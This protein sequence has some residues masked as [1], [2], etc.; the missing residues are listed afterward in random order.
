MFRVIGHNEMTVLLVI[1]KGITNVTGTDNNFKLSYKA[2]GMCKYFNKLLSTFSC[3]VTSTIS[4]DKAM[5]TQLHTN[6]KLTPC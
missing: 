5:L 3:Y 1:P 6:E 2:Y 4:T